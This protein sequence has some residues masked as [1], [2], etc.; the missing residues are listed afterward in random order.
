MLRVL[1]DGQMLSLQAD[2]LGLR[3]KKLVVK[4]GKEKE[5]R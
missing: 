5:K 1:S 4:V 2:F 3:S